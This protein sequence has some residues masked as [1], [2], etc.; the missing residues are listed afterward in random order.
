MIIIIQDRKCDDTHLFLKL[1]SLETRKKSEFQKGSEPMTVAYLASISLSQ[2]ECWIRYHV[3]RMDR[4]QSISLSVRY[5]VLAEVVHANEQQE[6]INGHST[7]S[8]L[9]M[10][11][12]KNPMVTNPIVTPVPKL[13]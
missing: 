13:F 6:S 10:S 7:G 4:A 3:T 8:A 12:L 2:S 1:H 11:P 9:Q 5:V